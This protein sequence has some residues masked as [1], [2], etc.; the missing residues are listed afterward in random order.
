MTDI[1]KLSILASVHTIHIYV[2]KIYIFFFSFLNSIEFIFH[3]MAMHIDNYGTLYPTIFWN[4]FEELRFK[5][6]SHS[7]FKKMEMNFYDF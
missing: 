7:R 5:L 4:Q 2:A 3:M 6:H 1:Y